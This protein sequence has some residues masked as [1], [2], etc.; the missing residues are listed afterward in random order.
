MKAA[1]VR[2]WLLVI[3][4]LL[5]VGRATGQV[6]LGTAFTFQGDLQHNQ[7]L[8]DGTCDFQFSLWDQPGSGSPPIGG[9]QIGSTQ[10]IA[11][12]VLTGGVFTV[13]L[14]ASAEFGA[15]AFD[16]SSRW[17]QIAVR[18]PAGS[19][20]YSTLTPRQPITATPYAFQTRG[21]FVDSLGSL[22]AGNR[23]ESFPSE[24]LFD[25]KYDR[26]TDKLRTRSLM[27]AEVSDPVDLAVRRANGTMSNPQPLQQDDIIGWLYFQPF[28]A[29]GNFDAGPS[30]FY[31]RTA[32]IHSRCAEP[33]TNS[34][35]GG[36]LVFGVTKI[37]EAITRERAY[38]DHNGKLMLLGRA[39]I[40]DNNVLALTQGAQSTFPFGFLTVL[41]PDT[42]VDP[43][44]SLRQTNNLRMGFDFDLET[45]AVGRLDLYRVNESVRSHVLSIMRTTGRVGIGTTNPTNV[46]TIAAGAGNALADGWQTRSSKRWKT[47]VKPIANP[48]QKVQRLRG[49]EFN[50]KG[51]GKS[52]IGLIAEDVAQVVPEVVSFEESGKDAQSVDYARLTAVLIEAVKTQQAQIEAQQARLDRLEQQYQELASCLKP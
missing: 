42:T 26:S 11:N 31:G 27:L 34:G 48:V 41:G 49:V 37:G 21:I 40:E 15:D 46:L 44:V 17:L 24:Y 23:E 52:D 38:F 13:Q 50:W 45:A 10:T 3:P 30:P 16:G 25:F 9:N 20:S 22:Y 6:P 1:L 33:P 5:A 4:A 47:N 12:V 18:F 36:R 43:T 19:G 39:V 51:T 2:R 14:N 32:F 7:S 28:G 8:I 35:R 29:P